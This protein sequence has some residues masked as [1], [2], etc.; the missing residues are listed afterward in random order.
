MNLK[1][2]KGT[3]SKRCLQTAQPH[4]RQDRHHRH[5]PPASAAIGIRA[6]VQPCD[7]SA[8]TVSVIRT[9]AWTWVALASAMLAR[10]PCRPSEGF[11]RIGCYILTP[12]AT[13]TRQGAIN[14]YTFA[15]VPLYS[16]F[17]SLADALAVMRLNAFHS[18]V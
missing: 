8:S 3:R 17:F 9:V 10:T 2:Q 4:E 12:S 11:P 13:A 7:L 15:A 16:A 1:A 6:Q 5:C 18:S 14:R